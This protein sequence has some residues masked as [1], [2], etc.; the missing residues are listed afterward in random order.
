MARLSTLL[1][2]VGLAA[3]TAGAFC[4]S[5]SV[6]LIVGGVAAVVLG[7]TLERG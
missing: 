1:E 5:L 4:V 6:G 3:I 2:L 7:V